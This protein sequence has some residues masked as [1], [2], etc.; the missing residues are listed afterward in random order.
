MVR[1]LPRRRLRPTHLHS[2]IFA[3]RCRHRSLYCHQRGHGYF[4]A[5]LIMLAKKTVFY[6]VLTVILTAIL[7]LVHKHT[8]PSTWDESPF[9]YPTIYALLTMWLIVGFQLIAVLKKI[10][11]EWVTGIILIVGML[12]MF[13]V[14]ICTLIAV[15]STESLSLI[16]VF[17]LLIAYFSNLILWSVG[18]SKIINA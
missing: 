4:K 12:K 16:W 8:W 10:Q 3:Y 11:P 18:A 15:Q 13:S 2:N 14:M 17:P 7:V 9:F 5:Q 6:S 1:Q